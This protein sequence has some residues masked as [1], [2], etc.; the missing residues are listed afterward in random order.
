MKCQFSV[1]FLMVEL[2]TS[3]FS[4]YTIIN[5]MED[6]HKLLNGLPFYLFLCYNMTTFMS[7][8]MAL[9]KALIF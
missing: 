4:Y 8:A 6:S 2:L 5:D 3:S 9:K 1:S 7:V